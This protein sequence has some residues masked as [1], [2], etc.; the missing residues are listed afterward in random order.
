MLD[1][2][3]FMKNNGLSMKDPNLNDIAEISLDST[4]KQSK[5]ELLHTTSVLMKHLTTISG[6]TDD[7]DY[8]H[9]VIHLDAVAQQKLWIVR[10][11]LF[12]QLLIFVAM[13][14]ENKHLYDQVYGDLDRFPFRQDI[15]SELENFKMGIFGSITPTSDID[16]GIQYSGNTLKRPGLAYVVSRFENMFVVLTSRNSL[17]FDIET[18]AD[19]MTMPNSGKD[20]NAFPDYFYLDTSNFEPRH[21][22]KMLLCAGT[23]ILRNEV[24]SKMDAL[25]RTLSPE[26]IKDSLAGFDYDKMVQLKPEFDEFHQEIR[27]E[28]TN[29]WL[30]DAS[31]KVEDYLTSSYDAGRYKYYT[32]VETAEKSKF[33]ALHGDATCD[34]TAD[35][36][37]DIM[38]N[39]GIALTYRMESYTCAPSVIHVVRILQASKE[40]AEKY[41]TLTPKIYCMG[42]IQHLDP[43]CTLGKY[44]YAL[45]C[46]E[47][48]GYIN[49]FHKTYCENTDEV[50]V[51]K[52]KKK[53]EKYMGRFTNGMYFF[54]KKERAI[55]IA[56]G[57]VYMKR[58]TTGKTTRKRTRTRRRKSG[59]TMRSRKR[60]R[61][62]ARIARRKKRATIKKRRKH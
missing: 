11:F 13:T 45:S 18:Y 22:Q 17:Q 26:E 4:M 21:F 62:R 35:E 16:I 24:L 59:K 48:M 34:L 10:T 47:Q 54:M 29:T 41:K 30:K 8:A 44:G 12:Y 32:H 37:C 3:Q 43:Y 5:E 57:N 20:K 14:L 23:S 36:I 49:R 19:M 27:G 33:D 52:C 9:N 40:K 39:I 51:K 50:S 7:F 53:M 38:T 60:P 15:V 55:P 2:E 28:L 6:H 31:L 61:T 25:G 46:L 1:L 58:T 56:G 42:E